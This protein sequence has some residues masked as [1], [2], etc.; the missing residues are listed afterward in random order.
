[1][2]TNSADPRQLAG[3]ADLVRPR[4]AD[5][6]NTFPRLT[7]ALATYRSACAEF[8]IDMSVCS[9]AGV[10]TDA[11]DD[12]L[13]G[14]ERIGAAFAHADTLPEAGPTNVRWADDIE[15]TALMEEV[16]RTVGGIDA[17]FGLVTDHDA[18]WNLSANGL[19]AGVMGSMLIG[20][21][22]T[23]EGTLDLGPVQS[24]TKIQ[25]TAGITAEGRASLS[26]GKD[27]LRAEAEGEAF[28]GVKAEV[29]NETTIG[30]CRVQ[31]EGEVAAGAG[32]SGQ[33]TAEFSRDR[34][35]AKVKVLSAIGIGAGGGVELACDLPDPEDL[36]RWTDDARGAVEDATIWVGQRADD[37]GEWVGD[38][39]E[40]LRSF[41]WN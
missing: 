25:G 19:E 32:G 33:A 35:A 14:T 18:S 23:K 12:V 27:G 15:L 20:A 13:A 11:I 29:E 26:I 9:V 4:T 3:Y 22:V 8:P 31:V 36:V 17:E 6:R 10:A 34:V 16:V 2:P 24:T 41:P 40:D 1:M 30:P 39:L 28:A 7:L 38:R 37:A 5:V 21:R